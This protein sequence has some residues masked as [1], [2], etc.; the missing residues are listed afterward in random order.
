MLCS[1]LAN[2]VVFNDIPAPKVIVPIS[3]SHA[4]PV[5][6]QRCLGTAIVDVILRVP[7]HMSARTSTIVQQQVSG[8]DASEDNKTSLIHVRHLSVPLTASGWELMEQGDVSAFSSYVLQRLRC[9]DDNS[10]LKIAFM[11]PVC[12]AKS[13]RSRVTLDMSA[14]QLCA[15]VASI[16]VL[17]VRCDRFAETDLVMRNACTTEWTWTNVSAWVRPASHAESVLLT[18]IPGP[19][20]TNTNA[21]DVTDQWFRHAFDLDEHIAVESLRSAVAKLTS[22]IELSVDQCKS[23]LKAGDIAAQWKDVCLTYSVFID[24]FNHVLS[25]L[26]RVQRSNVPPCMEVIYTK[27]LDDLTGKLAV[28]VRDAITGVEVQYATTSTNTNDHEFKLSAVDI[29]AA[30][31]RGSLSTRIVSERL[32]Q[33]LM[34]WVRVYR[35]VRDYSECQ[36]PSASTA[37]H[38][39]YAHTLAMRLFRM[40]TRVSVRLCNVDTFDGAARTLMRAFPQ[41]KDVYQHVLDCD[42]W[43]DTASYMEGELQ[44]Y[45]KNVAR[46]KIV[47]L[48]RECMGDRSLSEKLDSTLDSMGSSGIFALEWLS[49]WSHKVRDFDIACSLVPALA[50]YPC[51]WL[52][53]IDETV[54][55]EVCTKMLTSS[56]SV[57]SMPSVRK[58]SGFV[59]KTIA[60]FVHEYVIQTIHSTALANAHE[61]LV[62]GAR[63]NWATSDEECRSLLNSPAYTA[64]RAEYRDYVRFKCVI[65]DQLCTCALLGSS[66]QLVYDTD[67]PSRVLWYCGISH[68]RVFGTLPVHRVMA[69]G[70]EIKSEHRV[71]KVE[72]LPSKVTF[73]VKWDETVRPRI[74]PL[75][76]EFKSFVHRHIFAFARHLR[77]SGALQQVVHGEYD[78][79]DSDDHEAVYDEE[80]TSRWFYPIDE[81]SVGRVVGSMFSMI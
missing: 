79:D 23:F 53:M 57:L 18:G 6:S 60:S 17:R 67:D 71:Q 59:Q 26:F 28:L 1:I 81:K 24:R 80:E 35:C 7:H 54:K 40:Y 34:V 3:V 8:D 77:L 13:R 2:T 12:A 42:L 47:S 69:S 76:W 46:E 45:A 29:S 58:L 63:I 75:D 65:C 14:E 39:S 11:S 5:T 30:L 10:P 33:S 78:S 31:Q 64:D 38:N 21:L 49:E 44:A 22:G 61:A 70:L 20:H 32:R 52:S 66:L 19:V 4:V 50:N 48:R 27:L 9:P 15:S 68:C 37:E 62:R 25:Q 72:L 16:N 56:N 74:T 73:N 41:W 55:G 36:N 43:R 51:V